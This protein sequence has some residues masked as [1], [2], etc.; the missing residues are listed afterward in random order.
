MPEFARPAKKSFPKSRRLLRHSDFDRVYKRGR[1]HFGAHMTVFYLFREAEPEPKGLR[2]GFTVG[3]ALGGAV[4]RNRMK[5][6]LREAVR[7]NGFSPEI[8]AD[9]VINPKKSVMTTEFKA[10]QSEVTKA[11]QVIERSA[12]KGNPS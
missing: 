3:K 9:V 4:E 1:R 10:L 8:T 5:R 12:K 6:R 11:F 2:I 7:L